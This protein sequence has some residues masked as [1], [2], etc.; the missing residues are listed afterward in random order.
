MLLLMESWP[1]IFHEAARPLNGC[2]FDGDANDVMPLLLEGLVTDTGV[3]LLLLQI[4][5]GIENSPLLRRLLLR[6]RFV[7]APAVEVVIVHLLLHGR[8]W[9]IS[10]QK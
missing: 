4:L 7:V 6:V 5:V 3:V 8:H 9:R 2:L 10:L 1:L